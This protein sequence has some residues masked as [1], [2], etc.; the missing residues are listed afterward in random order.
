[1]NDDGG[2][3]EWDNEP[4]EKEWVDTV[5]GLTCYAKKAQGLWSLVWVCQGEGRPCLR[6]G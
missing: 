1:M 6:D 5:T 2:S 3:G 4:D